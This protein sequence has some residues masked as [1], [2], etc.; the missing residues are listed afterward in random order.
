MSKNWI[1][2]FELMLLDKDGKGIN[3]TDFKVT[4]NIEWYN[5]SNPRAAIFKIY[6]LSQNTINRITGSE[7]SKLRVIA[8]Y[9]GSTSPNGQN[10]DANFGEI[11]SG[12]IRYTITGRDSPTD[13]FILIQAIDG[14]N[15]FINAT[16]NQTIAAGYT[17]ADINDLLM[18][19]L[20]PFGITQG[21]MPEMPPT[22]FPRGKTM[23]G[24]TR[25]YLDNVAKQCKATW[26]FVNG[27]VEMVPND[28]YVHEAIVLNSD[29]GL[30]G[31]PQQTIGAGVNVRCLIN[32]NIRLNG[33]IQLN[34]ESV[35][36]A[37]LSSRDVQ[38]S[39]GRLEDQTDNGNVS[40]NGL[41]NPPASIATDGVYIVRG[42]SYTGDTRGNPWYMDMMC[43]ARG[44]RDLWSSSN[45]NKTA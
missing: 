18:R 27:K 21:I 29:T 20:A 32:P 24:M 41:T 9:D 36:R 17:V 39:G 40:V 38:M 26:Q 22:V 34:Q 25:D 43:E 3:F 30:I 37:T 35:Y 6:N 5:I 2:H 42:I 44:A 33:L 12:D 45:S 7:F 28:K 1:R 19:N 31:M 16:I 4:F 11:F 14:H 13:T 15:A 8:G 10:E 23:Y